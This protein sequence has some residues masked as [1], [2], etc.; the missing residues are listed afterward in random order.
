MSGWPAAETG[1]PTSRAELEALQKQLE[2]RNAEALRQQQERD[3]LDAE[4]QRLRAKLA[5]TREAAKA[6]EKEDT[7]DYTEA[8]TRKFL[9]DVD[10]RRAGWLLEEPR[11]REYKVSGMPNPQGVGYVDYVLWGDDGK[12]LGLVEAKR[13]LV[14]ATEGQQQAKL[15]ADCLEAAHGRRPLIFYSNGYKTWLWDDLFYPPRR[16][17]GFYKKDELERLI[18]RRE[19]REPLDV[20]KIRAA[21]AGRYYQKRAIGNIFTAFAGARRKSL[22]VMATGTGKTRTAIALV[23]VLQRANWVKR[24]LFLADRLSLVN[25]AV[26]AFKAHLPEASPVNLVTEKHKEGRVYVCT[27]PTMMGLIDE[28]KGGGP[29]RPG[30]F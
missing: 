16:V 11:D 10:L 22:L 17:A 19:A 8:E 24:A 18:L 6:T 23:Y 1:G 4:L 26:N 29:L 25:Q 2:A 5:A 30:V 12:P 28:T 9:I 7:H 21:I 15:Y 14:D 27:Y 20:A 13:T 3:A